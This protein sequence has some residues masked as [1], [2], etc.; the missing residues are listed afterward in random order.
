MPA[1]SPWQ[2]ASRHVVRALCHLLS[3]YGSEFYVNSSRCSVRISTR[4]RQKFR[5]WVNCLASTARNCPCLDS[6]SYPLMGVSARP[7]LPTAT[8]PVGGGGSSVPPPPCPLLTGGRAGSAR[9]AD[10]R[11]AGGLSRPAGPAARGRA[12]AQPSLLAQ[13]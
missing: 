4:S 3:R 5:F 10:R 13:R 7:V 2:S 1:P 12:G 11:V 6:G 8:A 9:P